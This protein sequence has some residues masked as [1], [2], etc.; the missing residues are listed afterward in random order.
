MEFEDD[1]FSNG[2]SDYESAPSDYDDADEEADDKKQHYLRC[3][4]NKAVTEEMLQETYRKIL[5]GEANVFAKF[6]KEAYEEVD[7]FLMEML[8]YNEKLE[9]H[10]PEFYDKMKTTHGHMQEEDDDSSI[11]DAY[12][13]HKRK[14]HTM[15]EPYVRNYMRICKEGAEKV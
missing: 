11:V 10:L 5:A 15:L 14:L 1:I 4:I 6:S 7:K 3:V 9:S 8:K 12:Q 2:D 13:I